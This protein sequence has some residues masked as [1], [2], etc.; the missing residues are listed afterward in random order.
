MSFGRR[1]AKYSKIN[2]RKIWGKNQRWVSHTLYPQ[3]FFLSLERILAFCQEKLVILSFSLILMHHNADGVIIMINRT[4]QI[5]CIWSWTNQ[6]ACFVLFSRLNVCQTQ[7]AVCPFQR[8]SIPDD[9]SRSIGVWAS[10][11]SLRR[12]CRWHRMVSNLCSMW[13]WRFSMEKE[14]IA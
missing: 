10:L 3:V 5:V 4:N 12:D 6:I 8:Q 13:A 1:M 7:G 11:G 2:E 9:R 14:W